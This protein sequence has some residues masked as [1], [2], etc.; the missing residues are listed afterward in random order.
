MYRRLVRMWM[1]VCHR[2]NS[3][4]VGRTSVD[5]VSAVFVATAEWIWIRCECV[6]AKARNKNWINKLEENLFSVRS[7]R[8]LLADVRY[9]NGSL[10]CAI[11]D[12]S[13]TIGLTLEWIYIIIFF[14]SPIVHFTW[15][16]AFGV[17]VML[18]CVSTVRSF[19]MLF[20][21]VRHGNESK[22]THR[23]S[24]PLPRTN[25]T[26]NGS[27][28]LLCHV[29]ITIFMMWLAGGGKQ[30]TCVKYLNA[31][32]IASTECGEANTRIFGPS[33]FVEYRIPSNARG[34]RTAFEFCREGEL[35]I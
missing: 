21:A 32:A 34:Q 33:A 17:C 3:T 15:V 11:W 23:K 18:M 7:P 14:A 30:C 29:C 8:L 13:H 16:S 5:R 6:R 4:K 28:R 1:C 27:L 22:Q 19:S 26:A 10:V 31:G 12:E 24:R 2:A 9:W 25:Y 35:S 20:Y